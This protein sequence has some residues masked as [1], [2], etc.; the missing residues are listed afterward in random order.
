MN[1]G[2]EIEKCASIEMEQTDVTQ[3]LFLKKARLERQLADI[4]AAIDA[5]Q[6]SP[7][8]EKVINLLHKTGRY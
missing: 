5:L 6:S 1:T 4:N 3:S 8:I 2:G 7:G